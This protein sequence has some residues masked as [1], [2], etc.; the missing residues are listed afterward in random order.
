MLTQNGI[1]GWPTVSVDD[2]D[3]M[4]FSDATHR[5]YYKVTDIPFGGNTTTNTFMYVYTDDY[6]VKKGSRSAQIK[7]TFKKNGSP[8]YEDRI[9]HITQKGYLSIYTDKGVGLPVLNSDGS[10]SDEMRKFGI[11]QV[12]EFS[13]K[14]SADNVAGNKMQWGFVERYVYNQGDKYRNGFFVTPNI[15]YNNIG[16]NNNMPVFSENNYRPMYGNIGN[17]LPNYGNGNHSGS[18][19]YYPQKTGNIYD[20]IYKS[21]AVRYCHEKNRDLNGDGK[22]D[23]SETKWYLPSLHEL[24][25]MWIGNYETPESMLINM[26]AGNYWSTTEHSYWEYSGDIRYIE[27]VI[28]VWN[29]LDNTSSPT[30]KKTETNRTRCIRLL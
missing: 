30:V 5:M 6:P 16:R 24:S 12:E 11:E 17:L 22:I 3:V 9:Y 2:D 15:G 20:P 25:M 19:Y 10:L 26:E 1:S 13:L 7:I 18:P 4:K 27:N 21:S 29:F 28:H 14:M 23:D 8:I